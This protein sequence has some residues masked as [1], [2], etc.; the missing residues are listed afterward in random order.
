VSAAAS[1]LEVLRA[2]A[3][4]AVAWKNGG[5]LTREV[6]VHP[7]G[8][9]L[10]GFDWRISIAEIRAAGPF[11]V[12]PGID[13]RLAVLSG[14]LSLAVDGRPPTT[15]TPASGAVGFPGDVAVFA[16]P[17]GAPV[18]DLNVMTRR[19]RCTASLT[20]RA[21]RA[22]VSLEPRAATALLIALTGLE[23]RCGNTELSLAA[24]DALRIGRGPRCTLTAY[25]DTA[26]FYLIEIF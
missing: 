12:F 13:R 5:G 8:S 7:R 11:S 10:D 25:C 16:E 22:T 15:L 20:R 26:A 3:R 6:A 9:D 4:P 23:V 14:T 24:L 21:A 17:L 19:A 18:T 1:S 2:G